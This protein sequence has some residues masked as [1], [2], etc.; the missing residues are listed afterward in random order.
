MSVASPGS[1]RIAPQNNKEF[2]AFF[3]RFRAAVVR[4]D[5]QTVASM[6]RFPF[7]FDNKERS[8]DE[9]IKIH[10]QLFNSKVRK[11]FVRAKP[12]PEGENYDVFCAGLI[13]YFGKVDGEYRFLEFSP[14]D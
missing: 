5:K 13:F 9:F 12:L 2:A 3:S 4:N 14:D 11:C 8:R 1:N 6:T 10:S 7:L